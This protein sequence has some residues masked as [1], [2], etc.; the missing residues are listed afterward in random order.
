[1]RKILPAL[2]TFVFACPIA[3][4]ADEPINRRDAFLLIWQSISRP[5]VETRE[6]PYSDVKKGDIGFTEITFAKARG[7]LS[8]EIE[9]FEPN[10][11]VTPT[12]ALAWLFRTRS[13]EPLLENGDRDLSEMVEPEDVPRLAEHYGLEYDAEGK[14]ITREQLLNLMRSLD[15]TL[16]TEEHEVSLYSE[17]FHGKGTAFGETFDMNALTAA[18]RTFPHNTLVRVTNVA[19]GKS[20]VVRIND[21]GPYVQGRDLDLSL[22]SF[23]E[24]SPRSAGKIQ[25][26]IER[27]GDVNIV[28]RCESDRY[29][30]RITKN[31]VLTPGI[32]HVLALGTRLRFKSDA[33]FVVRNMI[34]PD[35]TE[36][37]VQTWITGDEYFDMIPSVVGQYRFIVGTKLGN[38]REMRME[39]VECGTY[40]D[41]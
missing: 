37:G 26:T 25:A 13:I 14:S 2:L 21:R 39:V 41:E 5:T 1:V 6:T 12:V 35:G 33:P 8:D 19:N 38:I 16:A 9:E 15:S 32:P 20:V 27:L 34:Y 29:Q 11:F 10:A 31:V 28:G 36:T 17:K 23:T 22:R 40:T 7:L 24:I 18:H 30:R 4:A 3:F